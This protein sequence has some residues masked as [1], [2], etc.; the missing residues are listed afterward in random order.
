MY[1]IILG[2]F[3]GKGNLLVAPVKNEAEK[4]SCFNGGSYRS[5]WHSVVDLS[6][7]RFI[8]ASDLSSIELGTATY[9]RAFAS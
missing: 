5:P 6:R 4:T 7:S 8:A 2:R 1:G 3:L 9:Q